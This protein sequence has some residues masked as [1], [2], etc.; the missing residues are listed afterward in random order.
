[1]SYQG[2]TFRIPCNR[3]G[4]FNSPNTDIIEAT[5]MV[6]VTKNLSLEEDGREKR[7]GTSI[8]SAGYGGAQVMGGK[9]FTLNN[10][11]Q[12]NVVA[13]ADGKIWR[14]A[15]T[16]IKTGLATN[17]Y[18]SFTFYNNELYIFNGS[19]IPQVWDGVAT[20]TSD[21]A[22]PDPAWSGSNYPTHAVVHGKGNS[23]RMW[24]FGA[25]PYSIYGSALN[26]DGTSEADFS[27]SFIEYV[28]TGDGHGITA[29]I[30][31][32]DRLIIFGKTRAFIFEDTDTDT[33]NWGHTPAQWS[34]GVAHWR[35]LIRTPNDLIAMM[36][37]GEVYSVTTAQQFGDYK[38]ASISRPAFVDRWLR[39]S[40]RLTNIKQFHATYD[41]ELRLIKFFIVRNGQA[42]VDT[43]LVFYL[44]RAIRFS[45][46]EAW[47]I[48]DNQVANS[49]YS[50]SASWNYRLDPPEDHRDYIYTGDYSGNV[51]DLEEVNRNDNNNGYDAIF[52][53][54]DMTFDD[55]RIDKDFK[56]GWLVTKA[57]GPQV[58]RV[59]PFVDGIAL[60][61]QQISLAGTGVPLDT[62]LLDTDTLAGDEI[63][64]KPFDIGAKGRRL[65][66][67]VENGFVDEDFFISQMMVDF[68]PLGNRPQ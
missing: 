35:V 41:P 54:P 39:Q 47:M 42:Q 67:E 36:E 32:G 51:W 6:E 50:A 18:V 45:P 17:V 26:T 5:Q 59:T 23:E 19:N 65:K 28:N 1:M 38:E 25:F 62:F 46:A 58:L 34:G 11:N 2:Q 10:G 44:D 9:D 40:A 12:F 16:T 22:N 64:T 33:A 7:G 15:T 8:I 3:G 14:N 53:T 49:G 29:G 30:E 52:E 13:T 68:K 31:F 43:A 57:E 20:S 55:P 66:I 37:D 61:Q 27:S 63:L 60:A 21:I 56:R 24:A 4:F 48:H